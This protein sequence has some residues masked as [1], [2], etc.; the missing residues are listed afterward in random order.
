MP[1]FGVFLPTAD[2]SATKEAA[3]RAEADGFWSVSLNDHFVPQTGDVTGPQLECLTTLTAVAAVTSS[4]RLTPVVVSA[5]YRAPALLAKMTATLDHISG[6]RLVL[7]LGAGWHREEFESHGYDF[8]GPAERVARLAETVKVLKAMW[9]QDAPTFHGEYFSIDNASSRP[10]PI[11]QPHPPLMIGGSSKRVLKISAE[12]ADIVNLIPPTS[13]G[14]DFL[15]DSDAAARFTITTL[16]ERIALLR[17]LAAG[18]GRSAS[19]IEIGGLSMLRIV[20]DADD[21]GLPRLAARLGVPDL[22]LAKTLPN[23][24]LGTP[25]QVIE[26]LRFRI[27]DVGVNYLIVVPTSEESYRLFVDEVMPQLG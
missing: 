25:L 12:D 5:A 17:E 3:L 15:K 16:R 7:G 10:R 18:F 4:V 8:P 21:P 27:H 23:M 11:Q 9:T 6:G 19:D 1:K 2:F 20:K 22:A 13:G 24:L 26:E 14:K